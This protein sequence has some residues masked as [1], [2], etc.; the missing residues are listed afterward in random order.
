MEKQDNSISLKSLV[1]RVLKI[2]SFSKVCLLKYLQRACVDLN[3][4]ILKGTLSKDL[5]NIPD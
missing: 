3:K 5:T 2:S 4:V 1:E